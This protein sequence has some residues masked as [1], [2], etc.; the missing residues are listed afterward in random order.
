MTHPTT[1]TARERAAEEWD[2]ALID[3]DA[4]RLAIYRISQ[5]HDWEHTT[6]REDR[7]QEI[8]AAYTT[9]LRA[10]TPNIE[11]TPEPRTEADEYDQQVFRLANDLYEFAGHD[12]GCPAIGGRA[13][14]DCGFGEVQQRAHQLLPFEETSDAFPF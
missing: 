11:D 1:P 7:T 5:R 14:C 3:V 13:A 6:D 8:A 9:I 10:A 4:L 2:P 12:A